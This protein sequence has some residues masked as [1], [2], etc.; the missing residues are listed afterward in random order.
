MTI[1]KYKIKFTQ[2]CQYDPHMV[3][4]PRSRISEFL[5]GVSILVKTE[6]RNA[7][8]LY[9]IIISTQMTHVR[10]KKLGNNS[11]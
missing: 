9:Y 11:R 1:K 10:E 6:C 3:V 5:F 7:I 2:F 4:D 8:L